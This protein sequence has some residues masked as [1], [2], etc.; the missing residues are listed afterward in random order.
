VI[1]IYSQLSITAH[2]MF[3]VLRRL[4]RC[5]GDLGT[6][7]AFFVQQA[8]TDLLLSG[9]CYCSLSQVDRYSRDAKSCRTNQSVE[10]MAC[11][12]VAGN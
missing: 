10:I 5:T 7:A 4:E 9:E 12:P 11:I 3:P 1:A 6:E 2:T 8:I